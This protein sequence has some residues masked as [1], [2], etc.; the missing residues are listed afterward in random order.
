MQTPLAIMQTKSEILL[1]SENLDQNQVSQIKAI[2]QSVQRLSKLNK[3]LLLLSK[4]ENR[5][6]RDLENININEVIEK[7]LEIF[8]DFIDNKI[9]QV[10]MKSTMEVEIQGQPSVV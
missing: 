2:Y 6:F 7:H 4:I 1:Q 9:L 10:E 5:Q 8:D 3:T